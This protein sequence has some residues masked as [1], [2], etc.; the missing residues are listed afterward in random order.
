[1]YFKN[2]IA[3]AGEEKPPIKVTG[4]R[5]LSDFHLW[6]RFNTG[7]EKIVDISPLLDLPA[8]SP[9]KEKSVFDAVYI[10]YGIAAW[11]NGDIDLSSDYLYTH[12]TASGGSRDN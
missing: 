5:P 4:I 12:G 2:G 10:D 3:Y 8:F 1:M 11:Q 6:V 7:E 9:L